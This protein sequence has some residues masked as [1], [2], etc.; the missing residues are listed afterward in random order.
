M[1]C[2]NCGNQVPDGAKFCAYCGTPVKY[3]LIDNEAESITVDDSKDVV[4]EGIVESVS[5]MEAFN[6]CEMPDEGQPMETAP[7]DAAPDLRENTEKKDDA[8]N[9]KGFKITNKLIFVGSL[10]FAIVFAFMFLTNFF[11]SVGN[12]FSGIGLVFKGRVILAA[13]FILTAILRLAFSLLCVAIAGVSMVLAL[14]WSD[15]GTDAED[16]YNV[17]SVAGILT[18]FIV[19]VRCVVMTIYC[20]IGHISIKGAWDRNALFNMVWLILFVGGVYGLMMLI[21]HK[22]YISSDLNVMKANISA[23]IKNVLTKVNEVISEYKEN[24]NNKKTVQ[25]QVNVQP[26]PILATSYKGVL[27]TDRSLILY[28]VLSVLTCGIYGYYF[29]YKM[30]LDVNVAC[31]GDGETT[32]GLLP[33]IIF[34]FLTC[35]IYSFVWEYKLGDRLKNNAGRYGIM[36]AE[37]GGTILMWDLFGVLLCGIGPFVAMNILIKNTNKICI[38]YNSVQK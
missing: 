22:P 15:N 7:I 10:V 29:L 6:N 38:A 17:L 12:I 31:E 30:A 18:F 19:F 2:H 26:Q 24:S 14:K 16:Y 37:S 11:A 21:K 8:K 25:K 5:E 33:F 20:L 36:F 1:F 34:S 35:G 3:E 28:I 9:K 32:P 27:K 4:S 13:L 23:S